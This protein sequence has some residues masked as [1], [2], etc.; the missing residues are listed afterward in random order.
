VQAELDENPDGHNHV[1][2]RDSLDP[3]L[4]RLL[5]QAWVAPSG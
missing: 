4:R 2:W 5:A 3:G 1:G